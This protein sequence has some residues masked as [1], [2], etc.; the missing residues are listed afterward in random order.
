MQFQTILE[1]PNHTSSFTREGTRH[2][3]VTKV[4]PRHVR[5]VHECCESQ[6]LLL[7]IFG[8]VFVCFVVFLAPRPD[9]YA[10]SEL[11]HRCMVRFETP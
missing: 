6:T 9:H 11:C 2:S 4:K 3:G 7:P 8:L 5:I 1:R 10:L